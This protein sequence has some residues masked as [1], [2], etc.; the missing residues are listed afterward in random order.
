MIEDLEAELTGAP[1]E[2]SNT[3]NLE[4]A[5]EANADEAITVEAKASNDMGNDLKEEQNTKSYKERMNIDIE[6][7]NT[8]KKRRKVNE[9]RW[10][11]IYNVIQKN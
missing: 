1:K 2:T 3:D 8:I 6:N 7:I 5:E 9:K 11:N 10:R 4:M